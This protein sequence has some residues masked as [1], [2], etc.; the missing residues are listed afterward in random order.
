MCSSDL[1]EAVGGGPGLIK[2]ETEAAYRRGIEIRY[3][4]RALGLLFDGVRVNGV[5]IRQDGVE[6][7]LHAKSVIT[8]P[9]PKAIS[10]Q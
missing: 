5:R 2:M 8:Q 7:D 10:R 4:T 1:V 9:A 3:A 6:S